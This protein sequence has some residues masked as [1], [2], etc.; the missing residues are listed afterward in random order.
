MNFFGPI[1]HSVHAWY[2]NKLVCRRMDVPEPHPDSKLEGCPELDN[3]KNQKNEN[4]S[5]STM[6][7]I[8][9]ATEDDVK[10]L[11]KYNTY[12]TNSTTHYLISLFS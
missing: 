5:D 4:V 3:E 12:Y 9:G 8:F 2:P 6:Q 1:T 7:G 11:G 10:K